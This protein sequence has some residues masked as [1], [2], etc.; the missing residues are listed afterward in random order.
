MFVVVHNIVEE[1]VIYNQQQV[2]LSLSNNMDFY[3]SQSIYRL[4]IV[5]WGKWKT[6]FSFLWNV[7][8]LVL[9]TRYGFISFMFALGH[10]T[11]KMLRVLIYMNGK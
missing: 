2:F 6:V 4:L 9:K 3:Y 10:L 7:L 1:R 5:G 8:A 11:T